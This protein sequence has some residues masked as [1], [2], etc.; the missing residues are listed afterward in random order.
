MSLEDERSCPVSDEEWNPILIESADV[1][2][3][4][5]VP[6]SSVNLGMGLVAA[7][8]A[9]PLARLPPSLLLLRSPAP[10]APTLTIH[11]NPSLAIF[12]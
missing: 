4:S 7:Q 8:L 5:T 1:R 2:I 10:T 11:P 12:S 9:R 3:D 6:P